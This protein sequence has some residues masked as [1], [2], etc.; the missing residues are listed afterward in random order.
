MCPPMVGTMP[1]RPLLVLCLAVLVALTAPAAP[2]VADHRHPDGADW[3]R[4]WDDE[5]RP[6]DGEDWEDEEDWEEPAPEPPPP[7]PEAAPLPPDETWPEEPGEDDAPGRRFPREDEPDRR[8]PREEE[9]APPIVRGKAVLGKVARLRADGRAAV[10]L[11]AP[12]RV[13][14]LISAINEIVGKPYKWG[15]GHGRLFDRG[16]DCSGAVSY[17]LIR[18][19]LLSSPLDSG[20][21][22]RWALPGP[23]RWV[24]IYGNRGH[25]YMEIAGLRLDT[26]S[27]GDRDRRSGVRWRAVIGKRRGFRARHLAGL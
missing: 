20:G 3:E 7:A 16:Y 6:E 13:R 14:R 15:G 18:T 10:P 12:V 9:A 8:W 11:G 19:G 1:G 24:T 21:L 27:M 2:A 26:S 17:G 22:S 23:G 4:P 5:D 25:A